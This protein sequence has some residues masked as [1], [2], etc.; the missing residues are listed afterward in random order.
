MKIMDIKDHT[1]P[2]PYTLLYPAV[3]IRSGDPPS[4]PSKNP[5]FWSASSRLFVWFGFVPSQSDSPYLIYMSRG[6]DISLP[7]CHTGR[8][9]Q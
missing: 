7:Q 6:A 5:G 9:G 8:E 4:H 2:T 1:G 3:W